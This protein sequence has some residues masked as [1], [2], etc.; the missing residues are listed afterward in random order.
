ML[1]S[2]HPLLQCKHLALHL[3]RLARMHTHADAHTRTQTNTHIYLHGRGRERGREEDRRGRGGGVG[4][5]PSTSLGGGREGFFVLASAYF[6]WRERDRA[7]M[8]AAATVSVCSPPSTRF[9]TASTS[10]SIFA[11]SVMMITFICS[12]R[13]NNQ[14]TAIYP[15][16]T[17]PRGL[18]KAHVIVLPSCADLIQNCPTLGILRPLY[19]LGFDIHSSNLS[20]SHFSLTPR[21][22]CFKIVIKGLYIH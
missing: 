8:P 10:R 9:L 11:A 17:F 6:P 16:G 15:L 12:C 18:N 14:P 19:L 3:L 22:K 1:G 21:L 2:V 20:G 13:N 5:H 7:R 4:V